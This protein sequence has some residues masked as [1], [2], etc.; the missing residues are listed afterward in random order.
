MNRLTL[1]ALLGCL[2]VTSCTTMKETPEP[3]QPIAP[4]MQIEEPAP[5]PVDPLIELSMLF[6]NEKVDVAVQN[7]IL[8]P[9]GNLIITLN[10]NTHFA[11]GAT[12]TINS[13]RLPELKKAVAQIKTVMEVSSQQSRQIKSMFIQEGDS[14]P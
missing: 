10:G 5:A 14:V 9:D 6:K 4:D 2:A 3:K 1:M 11:E 13:T 12:I 8:S 7:E